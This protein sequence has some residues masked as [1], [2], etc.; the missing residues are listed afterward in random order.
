MKS[1]IY[2]VYF[3]VIWAGWGTFMEYVQKKTNKKKFL[4]NWTARA[5]AG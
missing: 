5:H 4:N 3:G 1:N 2:L